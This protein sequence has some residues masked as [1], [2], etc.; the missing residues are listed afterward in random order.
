MALTRDSL[1]DCQWK[2]ANGE[3]VIVNGFIQD[4][5]FAQT[6]RSSKAAQWMLNNREKVNAKL[7]KLLSDYAVQG[8]DYQDC[9]DFG[10]SYFTDRDSRVFKQNFHGKGT[11]YNVGAY[12][13]SNLANVVE[14]Y[15]SKL[16]PKDVKILPMLTA[17]ESERNCTGHLADMVTSYKEMSPEDYVTSQDYEYWDNYFEGVV[18]WFR[19][20]AEEQKYAAFKYD[21]FVYYMFLVNRSVRSSSKDVGNAAIME[22]LRSTAE[23]CGM[24]Q[25][26]AEYVYKKMKKDINAHE[27]WTFGFAQGILEM[28][29]A[30]KNGWKPE[31]LRGE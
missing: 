27:P 6:L 23:L 21:E 31:F 15:R 17:D 13:M 16:N 3:V 1:T 4:N 29:E 24:G 2:V 14:S 30:V 26:L 28:L 22:Q 20:H 8:G 12:V 5:P 11:S 7:G 10:L 25:A 9:F 19:E 18:D